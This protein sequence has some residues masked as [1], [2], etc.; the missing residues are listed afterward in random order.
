MYIYVY[1]Y[2]YIYILYIYVYIRSCYR[3][4]LSAIWEIF[5]EFLMFCNLLQLMKR[6]QN[7]RNEE[8]VCQ[9]CTRQ[10]AIITLSLNACLNKMYQGLSYLLIVSDFL[11]K[12]NAILVQIS[13]KK[14]CKY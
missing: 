8:S 5:S 7:M 4:V 14:N 6:Q 12:F 10:P 1:I 9:Y 13:R 11:N 3:T 2:I